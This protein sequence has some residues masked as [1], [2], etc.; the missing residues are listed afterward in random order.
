MLKGVWK[1]RFL[2]GVLCQSLG[3]TFFSFASLASRALWPNDRALADEHVSL[4]SGISLTIRLACF[5]PAAPGGVHLNP[6]VTLALAAGLRIS[7]WKAIL[8]VGG[9]VTGGCKRLWGRSAPLCH[10]G[11]LNQVSTI[12]LSDGN[13]Q[14]EMIALVNHTYDKLDF[15]HPLCC[16]QIGLTGCGMN[17]V[18]SFGPAVVTLNF[19][20]H[21]VPLLILP[22]MY[23][24]SFVFSSPDRE[25]C[26]THCSNPAGV[27]LLTG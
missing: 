24:D 2:R 10:Q 13:L 9:A 11:A 20:S 21:W 1:L 17:P 8:Y 15:F 18:R 27:D 3:T 7:P 6:A 23:F 4:P 16:L 14:T 12:S 26:M 19:H 5:G 22:A 25:H